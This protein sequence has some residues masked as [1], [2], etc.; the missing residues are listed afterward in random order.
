MIFFVN[1]PFTFPVFVC[2]FP[3]VADLE[4]DYE[5]GLSSARRLSPLCVL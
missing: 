1:S 5:P 3:S 2:A 4:A